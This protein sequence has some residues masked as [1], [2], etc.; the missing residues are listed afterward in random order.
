VYTL[1]GFLPLS[2][3]I[4]STVEQRALDAASAFKNVWMDKDFT[5]YY[6]Q[7]I[8]EAYQRL[9]EF[10]HKK[11]GIYDV[12]K[13]ASVRAEERNSLDAIFLDAEIPKIMEELFPDVSLN[14]YTEDMIKLTSASGQLPPSFDVEQVEE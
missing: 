9:G 4:R 2:G 12:I 3:F 1:Y 11:N 5:Y 14:E 10:L 13:A 7:L 6:D 8:G